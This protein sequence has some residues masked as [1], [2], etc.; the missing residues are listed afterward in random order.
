VDSRG[1][2][3][4]L[5]LPLLQEADLTALA[6]VSLVSHSTPNN[7]HAEHRVGVSWEEVKRLVIENGAASTSAAERA[8]DAS[9][10]TVNKPVTKTGC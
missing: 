4:V 6:H 10:P 2:T 5:S 7:I 9:F 3:H 1:R 8:T